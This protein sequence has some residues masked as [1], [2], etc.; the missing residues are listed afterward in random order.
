MLGVG[1]SLSS[2]IAFLRSCSQKFNF[3]SASRLYASRRS[4]SVFQRRALWQSLVSWVDVVKFDVAS[5]S[6]G[7]IASCLVPLRSLFTLYGLFLMSVCE[8]RACGFSIIVLAWFQIEVGV[9]T[10]G[11]ATLRVRSIMSCRRAFRG[12]LYIYGNYCRGFIFVMS[13]VI[14]KATDS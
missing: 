12:V 14:S 4:A 8:Y 3:S 1:Y 6:V 11:V 2:L 9:A 5:L 13:Y 7:W 10:V